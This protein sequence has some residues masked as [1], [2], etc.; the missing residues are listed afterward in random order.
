MIVRFIERRIMHVLTRY[1]QTLK[2]EFNFE[3]SASAV[4]IHVEPRL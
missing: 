3:A 2:I 1:W 4:A